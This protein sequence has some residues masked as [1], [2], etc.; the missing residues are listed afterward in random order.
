MSRYSLGGYVAALRIRSKPTLLV[1]GVTEQFIV[2]R[3]LHEVDSGGIPLRDAVLIDRAEIVKPPEGGGWSGNR[4]IVEEVHAYASAQGAEL[5]ALVDREYRGFNLEGT[6]HDSLGSHHV[7]GG[8]LFWTRGHSIE[9]YFFDHSFVGDFLKHRL[10]HVV[11]AEQIQ[12]IEEGASEAMTWICA[13][14]IAANQCGL[15]QRIGGT[16][17]PTHWAFD[18]NG[19]PSLNI[20]R[21]RGCLV[22]RRVEVEDAQRLGEQC[23]T[24]QADLT[25]CPSHTVR[26]LTH[27]HVG[28]YGFWSFV[29][30]VLVRL[31]ISTGDSQ[32]VLQAQERR[33]HMAGIWATYVNAPPS[34][35]STPQD[36]WQ[37]LMTQTLVRTA[38]TGQDGTLP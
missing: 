36:L 24:I 17:A 11:S 5:T 31:G 29:T 22:S 4:I 26:W 16:P 15:L 28:T 12:S 13:I 18:P 10:P 7:P 35:D 32:Q 27:G 2:S 8:G 33:R 14:A 3:V 9:N 6:P 30:A 1:E 25:R 34:P 23:R 21:I 37:H 38:R 20:D 19:K